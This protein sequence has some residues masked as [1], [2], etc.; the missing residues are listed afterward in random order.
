MAECPLKVCEHLRR[1]HVSSAEQVNING[2]PVTMA[3]RQG[4]T[5]DQGMA[6]KR[7]NFIK[8]LQCG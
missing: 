2:Y 6:N 1:V 4:S 8:L 5:S 3:Q 7:G